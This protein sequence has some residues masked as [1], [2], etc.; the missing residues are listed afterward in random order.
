MIRSN[1]F[2]GQQRIIQEP[3][4][5]LD[6]NANGNWAESTQSEIQFPDDSCEAFLL[7]VRI[8]YF[9]LSQ[10]SEKL[11]REELVDLA[12]LADKHQ[13]ED[14]VRLGLELKKWMVL[15]QQVHKLWPPNTNL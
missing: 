15:Y 6:N 2:P 5:H 3:E 14:A 9:Q 1:G 10:L 13:L 7:V 11:S 4:C 8:A 12:L